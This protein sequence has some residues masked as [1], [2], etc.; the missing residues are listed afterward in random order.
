MLQA[1]TAVFTGRGCSPDPAVFGVGIQRTRQ[2]T[3]AEILMQTDH[4][5]RDED[6]TEETDP[7]KLTPKQWSPWMN[8][9][10]LPQT[11]LKYH[12]ELVA[13]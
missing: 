13:R 12:A 9:V 7:A 3:T 5:T 11:T 8:Y 10:F 4:A 2:R 6:P 1:S